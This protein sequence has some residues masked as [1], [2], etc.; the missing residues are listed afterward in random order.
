[1]ADKPLGRHR[2]RAGGE[3]L[4]TMRAKYTRPGGLQASVAGRRLRPGLRGM[5]AAV[6][7]G[8]SRARLPR[9]HPPPTS[10]TT[11][12]RAGFERALLL[13]R[14]HPAGADDRKP[15]LV[16]EMA[17]QRYFPFDEPC[18]GDGR[19]T[20]RLETVSRPA[21]DLSRPP[22]PR[23]REH[24][25]DGRRFLEIRLGRQHYHQRDIGNMAMMTHFGVPRR[26]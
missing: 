7:L 24:P 23:P 14:E 22:S 6:A 16:P 4:R 25:V 5:P 2:D 17:A 19:K 12:R 20:P 11:T 3:V 8:A 1:M 13:E 15:S 21:A 10:A 9:R 26:A 18:V